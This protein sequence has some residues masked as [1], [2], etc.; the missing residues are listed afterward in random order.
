MKCDIQCNGC[1]RKLKEENG[2]LR[3]DIFE[4]KKEWGY[5]SRKDL[6]VDT[7]YLCEDCYDHLIE[8]FV[9]PLRR[10]DKLEVL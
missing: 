3:E 9:V 5:F 8:T 4:G 2:L 7:F 6:K 1:G 10:E